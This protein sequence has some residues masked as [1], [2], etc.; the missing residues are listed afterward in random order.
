MHRQVK[1][2]F[3][4]KWWKVVTFTVVVVGVHIFLLVKLTKSGVNGNMCV[5]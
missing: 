4:W 1:F 2:C 5:Q 3:T